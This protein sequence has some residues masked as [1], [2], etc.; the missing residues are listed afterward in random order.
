M[1]ICKVEKLFAESV[2]KM[3]E[4]LAICS[5]VKGLESLRKCLCFPHNAFTQIHTEFINISLLHT[6]IEGKQWNCTWPSLLQLTV[7]T[8]LFLSAVIK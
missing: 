8:S 3:P 5:R 6:Y 1:W 2:G 4:L 7:L